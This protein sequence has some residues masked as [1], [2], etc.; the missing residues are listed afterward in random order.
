LK[1]FE[2]LR[3]LKPEKVFDD[4]CIG[5]EEFYEK[6]IKPQFA[7]RDTIISIHNSFPRNK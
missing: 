5:V 6:I 2:A 3:T 4:R 7:H 1:A